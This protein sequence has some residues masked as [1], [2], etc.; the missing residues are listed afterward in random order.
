MPLSLVY[1]SS[2]VLIIPIPPNCCPLPYP[3]P[4][5]AQPIPHLPQ[6]VPTSI[7]PYMLELVSVFCRFCFRWCYWGEFSDCTDREN[8]KT[9]CR[10]RF[11]LEHV[12]TKALNH[13]S[14]ECVKMDCVGDSCV[15]RVLPAEMN[16]PLARMILSQDV[17]QKHE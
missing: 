7:I 4:T 14:Q 3:T 5:F 17:E 11:C 6:Y 1:H 2:S 13:L 8:W 9:L 15:T 12:L 16:E 10:E